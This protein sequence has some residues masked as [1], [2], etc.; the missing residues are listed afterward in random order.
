MSSPKTQ[1]WEERKSA[2]PTGEE[3]SKE[4][5]VTFN[6]PNTPS[7]ILHLPSYE[8]NMW[9]QK[10]LIEN[11]SR[12][13]ECANQMQM[14]EYGQLDDIVEMEQTKQDDVD[15]V[16]WRDGLAEISTLKEW[17]KK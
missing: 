14:V 3:P 7:T 17:D 10:V 4:K 9:E 1:G 11:L 15:A 5:V 16:R 8:Y 6:L 13:T 2:P 12:Y